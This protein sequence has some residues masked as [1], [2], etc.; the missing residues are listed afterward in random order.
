MSVLCREC[1]FDRDGN[2]TKSGQVIDGAFHG[3]VIHL[4]RDE[5]GGVIERFFRDVSTGELTR[6]EL[7]GAFGKTEDSLYQ[8][9][10]LQYRCLLTYDE[11]GHVI[12]W[13]TLDGQGKQFGRMVEN[14]DK[15]GN[16][17]ERWDY[18]TENDTIVYFQQTFDPKT[19]VEHFIMFNP[20]GGV[21]LT[22]TAIGGK[23]ES[24]WKLPDAPRQFGDNFTEQANEDT[25]EN[26][27]C[28]S[29]TSCRLSRVHREYL[30]AERRNPASVEWRDEDDNLRYAAYYDY[31]IDAY[32]NWTSRKIWVWLGSLD[33]RKL[34]ETDS[35][36]I[37]YWSQQSIPFCLILYFFPGLFLLR[38]RP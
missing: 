31:E 37:S 35:R 8:Q 17:K 32:G 9:G 38:S 13:L 15:D 29:R 6:H 2:Q 36:V 22:W 23:L 21:S 12:D 27:D 20:F 25:W 7:L 3:E 26:Y 11:Y 33:E 4:V 14:I 10:R 19:Q 24:F 1:E 34:Y 30:D 28:E 18:G 16:N 5:K